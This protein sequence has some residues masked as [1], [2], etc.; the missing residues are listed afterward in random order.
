MNLVIFLFLVAVIGYGILI[1]KKGLGGKMLLVVV[2][3]IWIMFG[4]FFSALFMSLPLFTAT[5]IALAV[6][7]I[8]LIWAFVNRKKSSGK[9]GENNEAK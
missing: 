4:V 8:L 9:K 5:Y 1:K 3:M 7:I 2:I 6:M